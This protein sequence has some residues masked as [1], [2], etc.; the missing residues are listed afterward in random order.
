[1]ERVRSILLRLRGSAMR[2]NSFC[3]PAWAP[4]GEADLRAAAQSEPRLN[5]SQT[6][7]VEKALTQTF[8]LWQGPPGMEGISSVPPEEGL[9]C[10]HVFGSLSGLG[11]HRRYKRN[12]RGVRM[13]V[14]QCACSMVPVRVY[15]RCAFK[16]ASSTCATYLVEVRK[17]SD[18]REQALVV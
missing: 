9:R 5:P 15:H 10:A 16:F 13:L 17:V 6:R 8:S 18:W 7:A 3:T 1:M 11:R 12:W 2:A 14:R 4:Y